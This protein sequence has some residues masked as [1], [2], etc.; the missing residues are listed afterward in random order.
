MEIPT[1]KAVKMVVITA[2]EISTS[3]KAFFRR[4]KLQ[5]NNIPE[6]TEGF[7]A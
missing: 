1:S 7:S 5:E 2:M 4:T 6:K 3:V